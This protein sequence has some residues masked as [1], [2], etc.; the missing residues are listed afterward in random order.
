M[1]SSTYRN[2]DHTQ[3]LNLTSGF[4][5][6]SFSCQIVLNDFIT[7][8]NN[9]ILQIKNSAE[10]WTKSNVDNGLGF[11]NSLSQLLNTTAYFVECNQGVNITITGKEV[12]NVSLNLTNGWN[13]FPYP[14]KSL[15][16]LTI[17]NNDTSKYLELKNT[18]ASWT[19]SNVDNGLSFLNSL[20]NLQESTGYLIKVSENHTLTLTNEDSAEPDPTG[21]ITVKS[22]YKDLGS[23]LG[24]GIEISLESD[25]NSEVTG[26]DLR[27]D[28]TGQSSSW[29]YLKLESTQHSKHVVNPGTTY[30]IFDSNTDWHITDNT[31]N[32]PNDGL[33][34]INGFTGKSTEN[35]G[36]WTFDHV[37]TIT[38]N[39]PLV[40]MRL[41]AGTGSSTSG[42]QLVYADIVKSVGGQ[43]YN[44][45]EGVT[46]SNE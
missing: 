41:L 35:N 33:T 4:N 23:G 40:L 11:L 44:D 46:I 9:E 7:Q 10:S 6:I 38:A 24:N 20:T 31:T 2:D 32:H 17:F 39:T 19:G 37:L 8:G 42:P 25:T 26:F 45:N 27:F 29:K 34:R 28:E 22:T 5:F 12:E 18:T 15:R 30:P 3:T 13:Y 16:D 43:L 21:E 1:S 36:T 14:F